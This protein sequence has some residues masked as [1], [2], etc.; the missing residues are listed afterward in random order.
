MNTLKMPEL[1][2][3]IFEI[4][5]FLIHTQSQCPPCPVPQGLNFSIFSAFSS[6]PMDEEMLNLL[7]AESVLLIASLFSPTME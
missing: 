3:Q 2:I 1:S 7:H 4:F 5:P 6:V